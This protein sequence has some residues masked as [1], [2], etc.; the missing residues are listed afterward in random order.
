IGPD[1]D[2][3]ERVDHR[4]L[5]SGRLALLEDVADELLTSAPATEVVVVH[6][7]DPAGN[8][9]LTGILYLG[10]A[11]GCGAK[12]TVGDAVEAEG[13]EDR[14]DHRQ[15]DCARA[16]GSRAHAE[17]GRRERVADRTGRAV[18]V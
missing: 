12:V 2:R 5:V 8:V 1:G 6:A 14:T 7:L 3:G 11:L 15:R 10:G 13:S 18:A 9:G 16:S 4:V 17:V